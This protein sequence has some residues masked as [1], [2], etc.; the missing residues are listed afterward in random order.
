MIFVL[1]FT[2]LL[3]GMLGVSIGY[4]RYLAHKSFKPTTWFKFLIVF[5]GIPAGTPIQWAGNHRAHHKYHDTELDPHSPYYGG[6]LWAHTGWYLQTKN[7]ILCIIY[8]LG[9]PLRTLFDAIYRPLT[10]QEYNHYA[11]DIANDP[12][13]AWM[14]KPLHYFILVLFHTLGFLIL[15]YYFLG[16]KGILITYLCYL[17]VYNV[18]DGVDSIGHMW[19]RRIQNSKH[20]AR[21]NIVLGILAFGDG[22]HANHHE[23][24]HLC[25]H[26]NAWWQLDLSYYTLKLLSR[27]GIVTNLKE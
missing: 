11:K 16:L 10:N 13:L 3:S 26:G 4:H 23:R 5:L 20:Q 24:P 14:S 7:P 12:M 19:G 6:L 21:N 17:Y 2:I 18:G 25:K 9:G 27:L 15:V 22:W 8:A 1:I